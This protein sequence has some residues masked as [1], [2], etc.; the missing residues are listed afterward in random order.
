MQGAEAVHYLDAAK[1]YVALKQ[2][3]FPVQNVPIPEKELGP[4][5]DMLR[6]FEKFEER[7]CAEETFAVLGKPK[8]SFE[9]AVKTIL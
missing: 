9:E 4:F 1:K 2:L 5:G 8:L 6:Y 7:F 3:P